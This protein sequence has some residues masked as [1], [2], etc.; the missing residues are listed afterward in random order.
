MYYMLHQLLCW[1]SPLNLEHCQNMLYY[2]QTGSITLW[3]VVSDG[4]AT[5]KAIGDLN[6]GTAGMLVDVGLLL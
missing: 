3:V 1:L 2:Q 5:F 6:T 4:H